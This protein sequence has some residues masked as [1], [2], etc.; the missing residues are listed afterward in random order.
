VSDVHTLLVTTAKRH[1]GNKQPKN[2]NYRGVNLR[3]QQTFYG[4][5]NGSHF[6]RRCPYAQENHT[7]VLQAIIG[8]DLRFYQ[9][10]S[11]DRSEYAKFLR[12]R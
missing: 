3:S 1:I 6:E 10:R 8:P 4:R 2:R 7:F 5:T 9:R 12:K 11:G